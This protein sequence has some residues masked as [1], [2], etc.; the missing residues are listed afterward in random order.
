MCSVLQVVV[1]VIILH[2]F[3]LVSSSTCNS[4]HTRVPRSNSCTLPQHP[5]FG[6][7]TIYDASTQL[8]PGKSVP[9]R[10]ILEISCNKKYRLDGDDFTTCIRGTWKPE[11]GHCLQT[12][13]T[14]SNTLAMTVT[15]SRNFQTLKSCANVFDNTMARFHCAR[16]FEFQT[17]EAGPVRLCS[18]GNWVGSLPTCVPICGQPSPVVDPTLIVG[19]TEAE[20]GKYPWQIALYDAKSKILLCGGTL[21]NQRVVL[22]AA[23]CITDG[24]AQLAPKENYIV[25]AGKYFLRYDHP[26]DANNTQFSSVL[27][28][29]IPVRY[30]GHARQYADDIA[31]IITTQIF[32]LSI[33]VRPICVIWE[34][35]R[36]K[37]LLD[38]TKTKRAYVSG[39][40]YTRE[41]TG[42]PDVLKELEVP[43]ISDQQC[44]EGLPEDDTEYVTGDKFCAGF[45][46]SSTSVCKGDS[47]GGL[48][49]KRDKRYY[50][51][52]I[53]SLSPRGNSQHGGC[54]S[55]LYTL[56]TKFSSHID[57]V[58]E[59]EA[60]FR[61]RF[62]C[63]VISD[64]N[65]ITLTTEAPPTT[66][67]TVTNSSN[68]GCILP[69]HPE[70]G[71]WSVP[72]SK[73][74][75]P[76]VL[77]ATGTRLNVQCDKHFKREGPRVISCRNSK[78][79]R[80]PKCLKVCPAIVST[81]IMQV[82]C[83]YK[84]KERENCTGAVEGTLAK[85]RCADFYEDVQLKSRPPQ[86]C[87]NGEWSQQN[88]QCVPVCGQK[89]A[90]NSTTNASAPSSVDYPWHVTIYNTQNENRIICSGSLL[91]ERVIL[92]AASCV[93]DSK[94][95]LG[96]KEHYVVA[97]GKDY[98]QFN[99][100]RDVGAQSS[101]VNLSVNMN[102]T[103][104]VETVISLF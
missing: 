75:Q 34:M 82:K 42:R 32:D 43:L 44:I 91:S 59:N 24:K 16:Y 96:S 5:Q 98:K 97:V 35:S 46:N 53:V 4:N 80:V 2:S 68:G 61:P 38:S 104:T 88:P 83:T 49:T 10:T 84:S 17:L 55:Q 79:S 51:I 89:L 11:I 57:F 100:D 27:E 86:I 85:F 26:D 92:T 95:N 31:I 7:W 72:G 6:R 60:K 30:K 93:T 39:W 67:A 20:R 47:G 28:M 8:S 50:I 19:G 65:N 78:W 21:L 12:C 62:D 45:L 9:E 23:H 70:F 101:Q 94:G 87:V 56:Y 25:A 77:V 29:F 15:C 58:L 102:T 54:N 14:I 18:N 63:P 71:K 48:V 22:T 52:G 64:C 1:K 33:N 13:P 90:T 40:G 3:L 37:E 103:V 69:N 66:I 74:L 81:P 76:G 99:D 36:Y 73:T 41:F